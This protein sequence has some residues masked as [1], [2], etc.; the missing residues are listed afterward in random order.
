MDEIAFQKLK[1]IMPTF[2]THRRDG[3]LNEHNLP[4]EVALK[5]TN[6]CNLRCKHCYQ[7]NEEGHHRDLPKS[8]QV[9]D[10][11]FEV[12]REVFE[13]TRGVKPNLYL[14]GGEPLM[15]RDWDRLMDLLHED[16]RWTAICTNG[17]DIERRLDSFLRISETLEMYVAVEGFEREHDA[18]RGRDTFRRTMRGIDLLLEERRKGNYKGEISINTV[19][20][21]AM[22]PRLYELLEYFEDKGVDTVYLSL[23]WYLSPETSS[24]MDG[25]VARNFNWLCSESDNARFSWHAYKYHQ[26]P[27]MA[28][29][30]IE[31]LARV[32][33]RNWKLKLR[34]NPALEDHE[35]EEFLRGSDKPAQG[36]TRCLAIHSRMD[37]MP[38]GEVVSCKFF[39]EFRMG[40][41]NGESTAKVWNSERFNHLRATILREGLMPVCSKCNLLYTRGV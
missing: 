29:R 34:Y 17:I 9:R 3:R 16:P 41:L 38:N 13:A 26:D 6:R 2:L 36:K 30:L 19:I 7:W 31:E 8:E 10:L 15:Y 39:P 28:G 14:W 20:T 18:I 24:K 12:V 40:N 5:L 32:R 21:D 22:V 33:G 1:R 27:R 23:L 25:Y 35:V 37:V 11:S 4:E